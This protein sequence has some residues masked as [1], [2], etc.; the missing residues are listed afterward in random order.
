VIGVDNHDIPAGIRS[1]D[2][3]KLL[4]RPTVSEVP[5]LST[6]VVGGVDTHA[7]LQ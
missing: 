2:N 6:L 7:T 1:G 3:S 4:L 5:I